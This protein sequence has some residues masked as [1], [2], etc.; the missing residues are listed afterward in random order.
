MLLA[1][2]EDGDIPGVAAWLSDPSIHQWLWFAPGLQAPTEALLRVM[3]RRDR[4]VLRLVRGGPGEPPAGIVALSDVD[5]A[6]GTATLWYVLDVAHR[7]RGLATR[8]VRGLLSEGF[9]GGLR[10]VQAWA[11]D[12]NEPSIRV[13]MRAG[14]RFAGRQRACHLIGG[15]PRDRLL[16]DILAPEHEEGP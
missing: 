12:G 2:L 4:H 5:R 3:V 8:G 16:F 7:G 15:S 13:L 9:A 1:P 11:V 14:F 6:F 10:V